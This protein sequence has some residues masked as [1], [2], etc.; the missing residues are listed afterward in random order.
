MKNIF[1]ICCILLCLCV[2]FATCARPAYAI[3]TDNIT[4]ISHFLKDA[5]YTEVYYDD[6]FSC[7]PMTAFIDRQGHYACCIYR[8]DT[9]KKI[10][11]AG[12]YVAFQREDPAG[13]YGEYYAADLSQN[14]IIFSN[15]ITPCDELLEIA[16]WNN[17]CYLVAYK[18][19]AGFDSV[20]H[21][22]TIYDEEGRSVRQETFESQM[23]DTKYL[24]EGWFVFTKQTGLKYSLHF[25]NAETS[26]T[27]DLNNVSNIVRDVSGNYT[28]VYY[29]GCYQYLNLKTGNMEEIDPVNYSTGKIQICSHTENKLVGFEYDISNMRS[30][31]NDPAIDVFYCAPGKG[32]VSLGNWN[33]HVRAYDELYG[34]RDCRFVNGRLLLPLMGADGENYVGLVDE[35]GQQLMGPLKTEKYVSFSS[36]SDRIVVMEGGICV[37]YDVYGKELFRA[38]DYGIQI[39]PGYEDGFAYAENNIVLDP[40]GRML[41]SDFFIDTNS[42]PMLALYD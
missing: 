25:L 32:K 14:R 36:D 35:N 39:I 1:R 31:P 13:A 2:V 23:D 21:I 42:M 5:D 34:L 3:D 4:G 28:C 27:L 30:H 24:G 18:K 33:G 19:D 38:T 6:G 8:E 7:Y 22:Y 15:S 12:P 40:D 11:A 37:V 10:G 41:I 9:Y 29:D 26:E 17:H 20:S 16:Y